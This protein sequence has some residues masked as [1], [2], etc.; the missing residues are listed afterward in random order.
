VL[1]F[2]HCVSMD[3]TSFGFTCVSTHLVI[4]YAGKRDVINWISHLDS[5]HLHVCVCVCV[6]SVRLFL[7]DNV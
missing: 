4:I 5:V 1:Q 3:V 7:Y 2:C 6:C